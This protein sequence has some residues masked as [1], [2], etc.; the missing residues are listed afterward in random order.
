MSFWEGIV[1]GVEANDAERK[2]EADRAERQEA[3]AE[4]VAWREKMFE[5]TEARQRAVDAMN[6]ASAQEDRDWKEQTEATRIKEVGLEFDLKKDK[7]RTE[8]E[9]IDFERARQLAKDHP[10]LYASLNGGGSGG[11][12]G[13]GSGG[14][15]NSGKVPSPEEIAKQVQLFKHE[16]GGKDGIEALT[17]PNREI[18][19]AVLANPAAAVGIMTLATGQRGKGN[20]FDLTKISEYI[21]YAGVM[22]GKGSKEERD[23]FILKFQESQKLGT[24]LEAQEILEGVAALSAYK[25][26]QVLWNLKKIDDTKA[27]DLKD[28]ATVNKVVER[29]GLQ[30]VNL[31]KSKL[32]QQ[33][34]NEADSDKKQELLR[35]AEDLTK[36]AA[37]YETTSQR[38]TAVERMKQ[39]YPNEIRE[40][41]EGSGMV[42]AGLID[43]VVPLPEEES[44]GETGTGGQESSNVQ[45][46][47]EVPE[48]QDY[49]LHTTKDGT[50]GFKF[51]N[52][53]TGEDLNSILAELREE[54]P[55]MTH[56]AIEGKG[57]FILSSLLPEADGNTDQAGVDPT[58][59]E[60]TAS[61]PT[62][63]LHN[64]VG[65]LLNGIQDSATDNGM[66]GRTLEQLIEEH[67]EEAIDS[68]IQ[69]LKGPDVS[70]D[71]LGLT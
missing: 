15:I 54:N 44:A 29:R 62:S 30:L 50:E 64:R 41:L 43:F 16:L 66:I 56:F 32:Q 53:I 25:P 36:L 63:E 4:D 18:V 19:E 45:S 47:A 5:A 35:Q 34:A 51:R 40:H 67:G 61:E 57:E 26:A 60:P 52:D 24:P 3:R 14:G 17:E 21:N 12:T 27:P 71:S 2:D 48:G 59:S 11:S 70:F 68:I 65:Q 31:E 23:A 10:E 69:D 9:N 42:D 49:I 38:D 39:M 8:Q 55:D 1:K 22:E 37:M 13:G 6:A 7:Y 33:A 46:A 20:N 58:A 28:L